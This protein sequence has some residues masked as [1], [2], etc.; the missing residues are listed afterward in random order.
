[1]V[2]LNYFTK[3]SA[4]DIK[5]LAQFKLYG[6]VQI[7]YNVRVG[8]LQKGLRDANGELWIGEVNSQIQK[9]ASSQK[10]NGMVKAHGEVKAYI[11][12][13]LTKVRLRSFK[14]MTEGTEEEQLKE[15]QRY[16][17]L[18]SFELLFNNLALLLM[19][20]EMFEEISENIEELQITYQK[21]GLEQEDAVS[22]KR[23]KK[24]STP[25]KAG[26]DAAQKQE[27][28]GVLNDFLI[29]LLAKPQSFLRDVANFT[30]KQF[31][32][33]VSPASL[34]NLLKIVQTPNVEANQMLFGDEDNN[35]QE[36]D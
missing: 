25:S 1:M 26:V 11:E 29:S 9:Q 3:N 8:D 4:E 14:R 24:K 7:L 20:P 18:L 31:C 6:L 34:A 35:Q 33:E 19:V 30:F 15:K 28:L 22:G 10:S 16:K 5:Q 13:N 17:R 32:T 2:K 23:S 27:A 36:A 21:L 12:E